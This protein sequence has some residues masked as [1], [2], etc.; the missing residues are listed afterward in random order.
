[1]ALVSCSECGREIST[2]AHVCP[3]CGAPSG[4]ASTPQPAIAQDLKVRKGLGDGVWLVGERVFQSRAAADA[5]VNAS[6]EVGADEGQTRAA[7]SKPGA[8]AWTL[9]LIAGL[10]AFA[11]CSG[12]DGSSKTSGATVKALQQYE[13]LAMCQFAMRRASRDPDKAEIPFV[14]GFEEASGFYFAWGGQ[15]KHMRMRNGLGMD[16]AASGSCYVSKS[17]RTITQ[18]TLDGKTII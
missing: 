5:F 12:G 11:Q 1:M 17:T 7:K 18:L 16:V 8:I 14:D 2:Q 10:F 6:I 13:A 3:G 9:S 15:T 4:G